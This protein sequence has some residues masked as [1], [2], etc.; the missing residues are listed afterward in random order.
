M[1][2]ISRSTLSPGIKEAIR[3]LRYGFKQNS[4]RLTVYGNT[5]APHLPTARGGNTYYEFDVGSGR[6][7]R[8]YARIVALLSP[9][10]AMLGCY[11][12]NT[13]YG[14]WMEIR[15]A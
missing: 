7:N 14:S 2:T 6:V 13:H 15:D 9:E 8:G 1:K 10:G 12:T 4:N 3:E 5:T 11:F